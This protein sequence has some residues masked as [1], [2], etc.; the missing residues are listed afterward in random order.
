MGQVNATLGHHIT[1]V[2]IAQFVVDVPKATQNN[3]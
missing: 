1:Q 2:A 3:Y